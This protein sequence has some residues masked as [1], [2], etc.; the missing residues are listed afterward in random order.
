M[1]TARPP[2]QFAFRSNAGFSVAD[3]PP[4]NA[5]VEG[6]S[7]SDDVRVFSYSPKGR[8]IAWVLAA[9]VKIFDASSNELVREIPLQNVIEI[10]FSPQGS[11]LS[12]WERFVKEADPQ[13]PAHQNLAIWN[14]ATGERVTGFSQKNQKG[15]NVTWTEDE[16]LFARL[17]T[18]EVQI[19]NAKD[20]GKGVESRLKVEGVTDFS[21]SPGLKPV[22]AAFV[23]EKKGRP[24]A[25]TL[26]GV[27]NFSTP[28]S[29]KSFYRADSV[30]FHWDKLGTNVIVF[31]HT[32]VDNT[33]QSYYGETQLY[34]LSTI[35]SF[36]CRVELDKPG[37]VH[38]VA[39]SPN[40]KEFVVVYGSMPAKATLFD[41]RANP[42]YEFG[43]AARNTVKF[44]AHGRLLFIGGFGNLAGD[45]DIW[46]RKTFKKLT[47]IHAANTSTCDWSPDGRHIM[48]ATLYKRLKVDNGIKIWHYQGVL[49]H[50]I[51][52][53]EMY[54]V[55]WRHSPPQNWPEIRNLSPAPQ[56]GT[57]TPPAPAK[58][59]GVYRP[60]GARGPTPSLFTDRTSTPPSDGPGRQANGGGGGGVPGMPARQDSNNNA[61]KT[62]N[63]N[64][65]KRDAKKKEDALPAA[66]EA[67]AFIP[68]VAGASEE[69]IAAL[70]KKQK[71]AAKKL[72]QI[73]DIKQKLAAGE[74]MELT[75]IK[76]AE[77]E[78]A[79]KQ[80]LDDLRKQLES[81]GVK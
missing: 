64:K 41:H 24:A 65:K 18:N 42:I 62:A 71:V 67:P 53:K 49:V 80:E 28:L 8:Y 72:K 34:F 45:L 16:A 39:W 51:D 13:A 25:V 43:Q 54:Q 33:G 78:A 14:V 17:A 15:W 69:A 44:N 46:D 76:K 55:G 31:T 7:S 26:Y 66:P 61:S 74:K 2:A 1:T 10:E 52:V 73:V 20:V 68:A 47:T 40:A 23:P 29:H 70:Q 9:H 22:V 37:P 12:T 58:P 21:I 56:S 63:K 38:D 48:T 75:Q 59:M 6:F 57:A 4:R 36:G 50:A 27:D 81:L 32:D 60:P 30:Q 5:A 3:G 79:V 19:F 35:G 77:G 11:Y